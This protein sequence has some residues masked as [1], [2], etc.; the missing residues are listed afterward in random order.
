MELQQLWMA[1]FLPP[2]EESN[3]LIALSVRDVTVLAA[4]SV[5]EPAT[6]IFYGGNGAGFFPALF[7]RTAQ[8]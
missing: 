4:F 5:A 8:V 1:K 2:I 7:R 3:I 6:K